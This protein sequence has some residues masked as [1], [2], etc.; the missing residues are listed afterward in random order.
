MTTTTE[1]QNN[2]TLGKQFVVDTI[3]LAKDLQRAATEVGGFGFGNDAYLIAASNL[4]AAQLAG[5]RHALN[6]I[7]DE[8]KAVSMPTIDAITVVTVTGAKLRIERGDNE[9][10]DDFV[11][12]FMAIRQDLEKRKPVQEG[13]HPDTLKAVKKLPPQEESQ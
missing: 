7:R 3:A 11:E 10:V 1:N 4:K 2:Q 8:I 12:R 13:M 9:S 6:G 5:N